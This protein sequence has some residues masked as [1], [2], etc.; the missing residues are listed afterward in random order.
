MRMGTSTK[1]ENIKKNIQ[2]KKKKLEG[3]NS[4]LE[5]TKEELTDLEDRVMEKNQAEQQQ[6]KNENRLRELS[7][8]KHSNTDI[9]GIPEGDKK[10]AENF[11]KLEKETPKSGKHR[12]ILTK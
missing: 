4:L 10:G 8:I 6:M 11:P 2:L 12:E 9:V 3:I 1:I 5:E 7:N